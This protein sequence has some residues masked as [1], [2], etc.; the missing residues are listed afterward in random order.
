MERTKNTDETMTKGGNGMDVVIRGGIETDLQLIKKY[1]VKT[2]WESF[3][4]DEKKLLDRKKW[5]SDFLEMFEREKF[6]QRE[7]DKVFVAEDRNHVF[8]GYLWVGESRNMLTGLKHGYIYD[9]HVKKRLR[10][11]GIGRRLLAKAEIYC[12]EKRYSKILLMVSV[13]NKSAIELYSNM[14]FKPEHMYMGKTLD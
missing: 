3:P 8:L 12:R 7:T 6:A 14:R 1:T 9:I 11:K 4:E 13:N 10:G 2:A 5:T